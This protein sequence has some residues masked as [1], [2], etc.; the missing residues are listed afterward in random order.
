MAV[1]NVIIFIHGMVPDPE[2]SDPTDLYNRF[3]D[4]VVRVKP[5]LKDAF[6]DPILVRWG[7]ELPSQK[8]LDTDELREDQRLTRA[9]Q[10]IRDRVAYD[11]VRTMP[12]PNN[13]LLGGPFGDFTFNPFRGFGLRLKEELVLR[14]IGDVMYYTAADGEK[15]VRQAV[16]EQVFNALEALP[17]EK[18]DQ[19][20]CLHFFSHSLGV[21]VT[22]DFLFGLFNRKEGY[23]P[24]FVADNQASDDAHEALFQKYR[25][26]TKPDVKE[27][28][29]G[30]WS[31]AAS[32]LPLFVMRKQKLVDDLALD[33]PLDPKR[34]GIDAEGPTQWQLFYDVDDPLGFT[35]RNLY[36]DN[37]TIKEIQVDVGDLPDSAHTGYWTNTTVIRE[38]AHLLSERAKG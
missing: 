28:S 18:R 19:E 17:P 13:V 2:P 11:A 34:I 5:K 25:D 33:D 6:E 8:D 35:T 22:H 21:T 23:N 7:H 24:G 26:K 16:Y 20:I 12:G 1:T 31:C 38:T 30:S 27:L 36:K 9:Q 4:D 29:L 3:W 37:H 32:Q 14:G 15:Y 10:H